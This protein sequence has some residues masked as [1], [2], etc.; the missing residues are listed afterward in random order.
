M[1]IQFYNLISFFL[2]YQLHQDIISFHTFY[3]IKILHLNLII[4]QMN[5]YFNLH[6]YIDLLY[7]K[8]FIL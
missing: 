6:S 8:I 2:N 7:L 3:V 5:Q 4:Y 1:V